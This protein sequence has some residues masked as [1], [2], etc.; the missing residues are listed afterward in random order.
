MTRKD[1]LSLTLYSQPEVV[2]QHHGACQMTFGYIS[3]PAVQRDSTRIESHEVPCGQTVLFSWI[4]RSTNRFWVGAFRLMCSAK[5]TTGHSPLLQLSLSCARW[6]W[7]ICNGWR[8]HTC[9]FSPKPHPVLFPS[10]SVSFSLSHTCTC[11]DMVISFNAY[12]SMVW[13][14]EMPVFWSGER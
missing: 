5:H 10:L 13:D 4:R 12:P 6:L 14:D 3:G 8:W 7:F 2:A 11:M 9:P 1:Q